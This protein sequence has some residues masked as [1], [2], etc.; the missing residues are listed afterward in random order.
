MDKVEFARA[1]ADE[2]RQQIMALCCCRQLSVS[3]IVNA[4]NVS[5]PTVSHHLAVLKRAGLVR[6]ER[7]G[8]QVF[9]TLNREQI[10]A[11]CCQVAEDFA[12]GYSLR[13]V[14]PHER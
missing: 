12:P 2:T 10:V 6:S 8:K 4:L 1:L 5:Q 13:V 3:D 9:Y 7:R 14:Q 11:G